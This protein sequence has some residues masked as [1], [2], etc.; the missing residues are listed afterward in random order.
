MTMWRLCMTGEA[1][2]EPA[3]ATRVEHIFSSLGWA[4]PWT[5]ALTWHTTCC[6]RSWEWCKSCESM[7]QRCPH[8]QTKRRRQTW[9]SSS[10]MAQKDVR[11]IAPHCCITWRHQSMS[12]D[13]ALPKHFWTFLVLYPS[14]MG[15]RCWSHVLAWRPWGQLHVICMVEWC[16]DGMFVRCIPSAVQRLSDVV[17]LLAGGQREW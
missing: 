11:C 3:K 2:V 5:P 13:S 4:F 1:P 12:A 9:G 8:I 6:V 14:G 16:L 15:L 7:N 17:V 10:P